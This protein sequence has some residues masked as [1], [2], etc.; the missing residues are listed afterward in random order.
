MD[1]FLH[2]PK[3]SGSS[4]RT[5]LAKQYG[6]NRIAYF[7]PGNPQLKGRNAVIALKEELTSR[8][9]GL[10]TGHHEF[11][12]HAAISR[13]IRYFSMV[14]E[15]ISRAASDYFFAYSYEHHRLRSEILSGS[16]TPEAFLIEGQKAGPFDIQCRMLSGRSGETRNAAEQA[17]ETAERCF[18]VVGVAEQFD[19]SL[20]LMAK[21]LGWSPPL[22]A[23]R[24]VTRLSAEI[25]VKRKRSE[26]KVRAHFA[27]RYAADLK[28]HEL[29]KA[30]LSR[31]TEAEGAQFSRALEAFR[32][33]QAFIEN[34]NQAEKYDRYEFAAKDRLPD[35][36]YKLK[37][38]HP[39][40]V[41]E[42]YLQSSSVP[43][44][45]RNYVGHVDIVGDRTVGGWA[46]DLAS[47]EPIKV[48]IYC[49]GRKIGAA[50]AGSERPDV[51][52]ARGIRSNVGFTVNLNEE[53]SNNTSDVYAC[54][55]DS[56]IKI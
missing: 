12:L 37:G 23:T 17:F 53:I 41:L 24:N 40:R 55:E 10:V 49:E 21:R 32:E 42:E 8:E 6:L 1:D 4:L 50:I 46:I 48:R 19:E 20:L 28:L 54:F 45:P 51:K 44:R 16:L 39:Y 5:I 38:S 30:K 9:I 56:F 15:P 34:A 27:D 18:A 3:T 14:R 36:Q 11:G 29:V 31:D 13:P 25:E 26:E 47:D 7:E 33:M 2:I 22:Y 35:V 43:A 52:A